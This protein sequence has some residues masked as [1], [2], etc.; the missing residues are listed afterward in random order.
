ML[1]APLIVTPVAMAVVDGRVRNS[2]GA[3]QA[4]CGLR[5]MVS[6]LYLLPIGYVYVTGNCHRA[7]TRQ[8]RGLHS[9]S[10]MWRATCTSRCS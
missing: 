7:C 2:G 1:L 10:Q 9:G 5:G 4:E 8:S 6:T 3:H